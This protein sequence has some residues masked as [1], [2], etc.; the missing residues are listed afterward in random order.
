[1]PTS[2]WL[3]RRQE[4]GQGAL[5]TR[6]ALCASTVVFAGRLGVVEGVAQE[7]AL[8]GDMVRTDSG[9]CPGQ[10]AA[11]VAPSHSDTHTLYA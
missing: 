2:D 9:R 3:L 10:G 4:V 8:Q 6:G 11:R 5:W 1:M 7:V